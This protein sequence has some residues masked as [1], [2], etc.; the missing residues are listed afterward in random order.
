M[1]IVKTDISKATIDINLTGLPQHTLLQ[2]MV[3]NIKLCSEIEAV[4]R[5]GEFSNFFRRLN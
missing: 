4:W 1:E 2:I 5:W 3:L